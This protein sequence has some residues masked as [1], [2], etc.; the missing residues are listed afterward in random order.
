MLAE[1]ETE[2]DSLG[3]IFELAEGEKEY[4]ALGLGLGHT[5][6]EELELALNSSVKEKESKVIEIVLDLAEIKANSDSPGFALGLKMRSK[7]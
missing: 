6:V 7:R 3:S 1:G 5:E 2:G 4:E